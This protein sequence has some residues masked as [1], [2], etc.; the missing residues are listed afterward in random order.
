MAT[1]TQIG[2]GMEQGTFFATERAINWQKD[3]AVWGRVGRIRQIGQWSYPSNKS[4]RSVFIFLLVHHVI[5]EVC[6]WE[7]RRNNDLDNSFRGF[8]R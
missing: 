8:G 4:D 5:L 2:T 7:S 3:N 1:P 6:A